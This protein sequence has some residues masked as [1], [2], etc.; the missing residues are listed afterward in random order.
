MNILRNILLLT[1]LVLFTSSLSAQYNEKDINR[2]I[3]SY[4]E[5]AINKMYEYKIPASITMAQGILES[6]AGTS[7]LA[8]DGNNHFGIKCHNDWKGDTVHIDDDALQECFRKYPTPEDSY[9]DH[10]AFL[11]NR[12][13]YSALFELDVMDYQGWAHGLKAA[14]YATNPQYAPLLIGLIDRYNLASLDTLYQ[15]RLAAGYF[16]NYPD[17]HP[18]EWLAQ[19]TPTTQSEPQ[20]SEEK[21]PQSKPIHK[22]I[23]GKENSVKKEPAATSSGAQ[24]TP[25]TTSNPATQQAEKPAEQPQVAHKTPV[26]EETAQTDAAPS[27]EEAGAT[28]IATPEDKPTEASVFCARLGDFPKVAYPFTD[29]PV[30]ENNKTYFVIA[31]K[32]DTYGKIARDV[33][34]NEKKLKKYNDVSGSAKLKVGQVVYIESKAKTGK[35]EYYKVVNTETLNYIAQKNAIRLDRI[36]KY[37]GLKSSSKIKK[38]DVIKLKK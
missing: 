19:Q 3:D 18:E 38:G 1:T 32:G 35:L 34:T 17:V 25:T 29:R 37:N 14:G 9:N 20:A 22:P 23:K 28:E 11:K 21:K 15:Q 8:V 27:R 12:K 30:F 31:Q 24:A 13:R 6:A 16:K 33:Q 26:V 7:R 10:S 36:Y 5:L 4:K 2:Y